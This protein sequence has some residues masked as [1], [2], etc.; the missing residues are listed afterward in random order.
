M[1]FLARIH[2]VTFRKQALIVGG[3]LGVGWL[4]HGW[5][6]LDILGMVVLWYLLVCMISVIVGWCYHTY[7]PGPEDHITAENFMTIVSMVMFVLYVGIQMY[8]KAGFPPP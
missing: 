7:F 8:E 5:S 2:T 4:K 6:P 1:T 3:G